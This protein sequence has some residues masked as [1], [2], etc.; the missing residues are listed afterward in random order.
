MDRTPPAAAQEP[1]K[2]RTLGNIENRPPKPKKPKVSCT[3]H[4]NDEID[5]NEETETTTTHD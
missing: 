1:V 5:Q 3:Y 4:L 2:T